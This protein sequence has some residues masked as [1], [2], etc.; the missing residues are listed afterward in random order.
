[1]ILVAIASNEIHYVIDEFPDI[2]GAWADLEKETQG[3]AGEAC[4]PNGYGIKDYAE[5]IKR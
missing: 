1:M 5:I 4:Q 3:I 2:L